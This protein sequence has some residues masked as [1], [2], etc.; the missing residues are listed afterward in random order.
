MLQSFVC[1]SLSSSSALHLPGSFCLYSQTH[2]L[3]SHLFLVLFHHF[4][5]FAPRFGWF[6]CEFSS[7]SFSLSL[8]SLCMLLC[9]KSEF[10]PVPVLVDCLKLS[11]VIELELCL[12]GLLLQPS[13]HHTPWH[14]ITHPFVHIAVLG[15]WAI[16]PKGLKCNVVKLDRWWI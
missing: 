14:L 12:F 11:K 9:V 7:S 13:H 8:S 1:T 15:E 4:H 10:L 16:A 6:L 3:I 2:S 5:L